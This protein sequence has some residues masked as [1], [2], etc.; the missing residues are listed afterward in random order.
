MS[1]TRAALGRNFSCDIIPT[2]TNQNESSCHMTVP[3]TPASYT[4]LT[5][6]H[7]VLESQHAFYV[8]QPYVQYSLY[9]TVTF[10][11][12]VLQ[13]HRVMSLFILYQTL[14]AIQRCHDLGASVGDLRLCD[15]LVDSKLWV[16][17]SSVHVGKTCDVTRGKGGVS[18]G[19]DSVHHNRVQNERSHND[20][21]SMSLCSMHLP[22]DGA[23]L[24]GDLQEVV[25]M[26]T[27]GKISNFDYL[28]LLNRL[29]GRRSGDP[30]HHPI[31]PWVSD[32]TRADGGYRD[33]SRSKFRLNKGDHQLDLTYDS[34]L[35][36]G[37]VSRPPHDPLLIHHHITDFLSDITYY[38]YKARRTPKSVLCT[39]VRKRWVPNEY[40]MTMQRLYDWTPDECIPEF[41]TDPT[42]FASL[43]D[44][45]PDLELPS[46]ASSA[47]DFLASHMTMLESDH[48]SRRLHRWIDLT[49]GHKVR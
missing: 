7:A 4:N 49:F 1:G 37:D 43:H 18:V 8:V 35:I 26:W 27:Y 16:Q 31:L 10:S 39:H 40:P 22:T 46:W 11:P 14:R 38:V 19:D 21:P 47:K 33:L 28:M 32:F 24:S 2:S 5:N 12:T 23:L 48:V 42:I 13:R 9:D 20:T 41:Y 45:L 15:V 3:R 30:N 34:S 25:Q 17:L 44:D 6:A 29:A 36:Y